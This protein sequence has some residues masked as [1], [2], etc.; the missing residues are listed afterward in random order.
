[1]NHRFDGPDDA[2]V[3]V[4]VNSLGTQ[5]AMW[6]E[7]VP[8]LTERFRV[9]R[10]DM[11]GRDSMAGLGGDLLALA[12]EHEI[13][14]F[15]LCGLSLG[16]MV[17]MWVASE[18][19]GRIERLALCCTSPQLGEPAFWNERVD[20]LR[21]GGI[22][23]VVADGLLERWLT[24]AADP[25]VVERVR[26]MLLASD[27]EAY[28]KCCIAIRDMDMRPRLGSISAPT[29]VIAGADDPSTPPDHGEAIA[30]GIPGADF[31]VLQGVRH[32]ANVEQPE[33]FNATLM[34]HLR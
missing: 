32:L 29:L 30:A 12:D 4:L 22:E 17:A 19:P 18:A 16:G 27:I 14:R 1:V 23:S 20:A 24:P 28:A 34:E 11:V 33:I 3:I 31:E 2:P 15:S 6:D 26:A 25:A 9:L 10:Y 21:N 7:Q 8:A 5:L 13:E